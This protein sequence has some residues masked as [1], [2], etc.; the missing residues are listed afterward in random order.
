MVNPQHLE[1]LTQLPDAKIAQPSFSPPSDSN[2]S[3]RAVQIAPNPQ[4]T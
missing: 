1:L 3:D 2:P 4:P